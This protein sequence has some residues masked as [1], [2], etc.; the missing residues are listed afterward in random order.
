M[1]QQ[2]QL[3]LMKYLIPF[4]GAIV[5]I[6]ILSAS[7]L[8]TIKAG[9]KGILFKKFGGGLE[10]D[11]IYGQGLKF[12]LP[13]NDMIIYNVREELM[14]ETMDVLSRDG[15]DITIDVA[16][17]FNPEPEKIGYL[18][19]EVGPDYKNIIVRNA[20]RAAVRQVVGKFSPEEI[21]STQ[22]DSIKIMIV[23]E[24]RPVLKHRYLTLQSIDIRSVKLPQKYE[25][26]IQ[27]KLVQ[28]QRQLQYEYRIAQERK[29]AERKE[30]EAK[31]I[32]AFQEIV[33]QG[34]N[35]GYL[36]WKGIEATQDLAKSENTKVIVIGSGKDGLPIILGD[37]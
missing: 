13:W 27:E 18:H 16:V 30:I 19:D 25:E 4:V 23:D 24:V 31:G 28:E 35:E 20:L 6:I 37:N 2:R 9:E 3:Q 26:A 36:R 17:R 14:E 34:I 7:T 22:R 5:L 21:Y 8:I 12:V 29:E 32:R 11:Y 15:L 1:S 33:S 10:K